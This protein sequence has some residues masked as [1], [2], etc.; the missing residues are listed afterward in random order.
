MKKISTATQTQTQTSTKVGIGVIALAGLAAAAGFLIATTSE[1]VLSVQLGSAVPSQVAVG[2]ARGANVLNFL[3]SAKNKDIMVTKLVLTG[4]ADDDKSFTTI[5]N[6][7]HLSELVT[8]CSLYNGSTLMAGPAPVDAQQRLT[9]GNVALAVSTNSVNS[10]IVKCDI[11]ATAPL[12]GN[13]DMFA[14]QLIGNG[15]VTAEQ[16]NNGTAIPEQRIHLGGPRDPGINLN[17]RRVN[18]T[19]IEHGDLAI[20]SAPNWPIADILLAPSANN[21]VAK[22][23]FTATREPFNVQTLTFSEEQ[24]EDDTGTADSNAY[25]N[26]I[27]LVKI[28]Y[29]K[30]D[31]T[32]GSATTAMSGNEAKFSGLDM[33]VAEGYPKDV[34]VS[35]DVP[36]SDHNSGGLATSNEKVRMGLFVD[37][38][39][40]DNFK[41]VGMTSGTVLD[42]RA[43]NPIGDDAFSTDKISTFVVR[44]TKPTVSFS[45][46]SPSGSAVVGRGEVIRFSVTA[47]VNEDAV[48]SK[49]MFKISST[50]NTYPTTHWNDC[51]TD[52]TSGVTTA[53]DFDLY[54]LTLESTSQTLDT[55]DN[56]WTLYKTT[57][58]NCD[59]T[60][61]TLGFDG[62]AFPVPQVIPRGQSYAYALY[63][64]STGASSS[65]DDSVR[66]DIVADPIVSTFLPGSTIN[67]ASL[68][69]NDS[70]ITLAKGA[71]FSVGDTACF[72]GTNTTCEATEER[73]LVTAVNGNDVSFARGYLGTNILRPITGQNVVRLPG[74]V[75]WQDDGTPGVGTSYQEYWGAY[76]VHYL[77][78]NGGTLV[79]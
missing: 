69:R 49:L 4:L 8:S 40:K 10:Y 33:Y 68:T 64:D 7:L 25:T 17:G 78:V 76:L 28:Q 31:G 77:T 62:I 34:T 2:G 65:S 22:Y 45:N 79:F 63:F 75:L 36:T 48:L 13:P 11:P 14:L 50:D 29:P 43:Q 74:S 59:S 51:D 46:S 21:E 12:N 18:V 71:G 23:R 60:G 72:S 54:N 57:G 37:K 6:D 1:P 70:I 47:G 38:A 26:N 32:T 42:D 55:A 15:S 61:A 41:V 35:I 5:Q 9:F 52:A 20:E 16:V 3:L 27:S 30:A 53:S 58:A 56:N 67:D 39:N 66:F 24:A 73:A 44:E 19:V